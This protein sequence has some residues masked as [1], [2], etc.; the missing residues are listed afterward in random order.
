M[1]HTNNV[2]HFIKVSV[3]GKNTNCQ[4][5]GNA[6]KLFLWH[7]KFFMSQIVT[8]IV[9][10]DHRTL[11]FGVYYSADIF[12]P[13]IVCYRNVKMATFNGFMQENMGGYL[14]KYAWLIRDSEAGNIRKQLWLRIPKGIRNAFQSCTIPVYD[15]SIKQLK[16]SD[17]C[18]L[19]LGHVTFRQ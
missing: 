16:T 12:R 6:I 11:Y 14:N 1:S 19:D 17:T 8:A 13:A 18:V 9:V 3:S 2:K 15:D 5:P 4:A 10:T 7:F